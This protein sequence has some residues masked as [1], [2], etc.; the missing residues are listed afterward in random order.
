MR[1]ESCKAAHP[2]QAF[3]AAATTEGEKKLLEEELVDEVPEDALEEK[4]L[5]AELEKPIYM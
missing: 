3:N 5:K 1:R 2:T 4:D